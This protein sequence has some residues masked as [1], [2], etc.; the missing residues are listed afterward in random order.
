MTLQNIT[1]VFT[2]GKAIWLTFADIN[3]NDKMTQIFSISLTG[4]T[5]SYIGK[6]EE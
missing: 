4:S 2:P 6:V 5:N 3:E 1:C